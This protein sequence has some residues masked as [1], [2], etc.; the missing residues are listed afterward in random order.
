MKFG[1][2]WTCWRESQ[3]KLAE[4]NTEEAE[5]LDDAFEIREIYQNRS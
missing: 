4:A 2:E 3:L 5:Y 1:A